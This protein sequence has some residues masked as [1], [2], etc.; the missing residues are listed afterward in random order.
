M[1][2]ENP[3]LLVGH[4]GITWGRDFAEDAVKGIAG[5]G[6]HYIELFA[7]VLEAFQEKGKSDILK[8]YDIPL[9]SSYIS[10]DI[11][12]PDLRDE[13]MKKLSDWG[14][15]AVAFGAKSITYG[16]NGVDRRAFRFSEHKKYVADFVNDAARL[17]ESKG[18][19]LNFHPHT[20]TPVETAEEIVEFFDAVDTRLVGFAPDIGQIQKGGADPMKFVK[21]YI[22]ILRLVHFKDYCGKV[23]WDEEGKEIDQS[24]FACYSPLGEG[25]VDL[26][27]ILEYLEKSTFDG[28]L[29][30]ELDGGRNRPIPAE[31][32]VR[33]NKEYMEKVG[34]TFLKR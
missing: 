21:D 32:A 20:G 1:K 10:N 15:I 28:P 7:W 26:F 2:I 17:M 24:G 30:I 9:I 14:D 19:L 11:V 6:F 25:V 31:D 8:R 33:I 23:D 13:E 3:R 5:F 22:S 29:M 12:S 34:Y 16:G 18:L 27:G 4:T